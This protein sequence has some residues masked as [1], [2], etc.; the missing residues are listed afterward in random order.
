[1]DYA[2][3]KNTNCP[4]PICCREANGDPADPSEGAGPYGHKSCGMPVA[5]MEEMY[6]KAA[7]DHSV[8]H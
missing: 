2:V 8:G 3:G 7:L 1:M 5:G 6:K 4:Y